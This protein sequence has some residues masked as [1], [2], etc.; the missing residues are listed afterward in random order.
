[1]SNTVQ[2]S[3]D[4]DGDEPIGPADTSYY[5]EAGRTEAV[6]HETDK[7]ED[8]VETIMLM[9]RRRRRYH[10]TDMM[11]R[12][13]RVA[14]LD[15]KMRNRTL[16]LY[17]SMLEKAQYTKVT[18]KIKNLSDFD[19]SEAIIPHGQVSKKQFIEVFHRRPYDLYG[20]LIDEEVKEAISD[21]KQKEMTAVARAMGMTYVS[22]KETASNKLMADTIAQLP[23]PYDR[24]NLF[25]LKPPKIQTDV[26]N[27]GWRAAQSAPPGFAP[28]PAPLSNSYGHEVFYSYD[29]SWERGKLN[30][31]G[32]YVYQ[33]MTTYEG[34][35]KDN[36]QKGVGI[37]TY[38]EGSTY[39][40]DWHYGRYS[41][42]GE[43]RLRYDTAIYKGQF[44]EGRRSGSGRIEF[45]CGLVYEGDYI[46]GRPHGRGKMTSA[47]TGYEYDGCWRD[48]GICGT[49]ALVTPPPEK[50]RV[51]RFWPKGKEPMQ[52]AGAIR[53]YISDIDRNRYNEMMKGATLFGTRRA[54]NL[55]KYVDAVRKE[56]HDER[57]AAKKQER[58]DAL[59]KWKEQKAKLHEAKMRALAG[60]EDDDDDETK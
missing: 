43:Q 22:D 16:L 18:Q 15:E 9:E 35:F 8:Q 27:V 50:K 48:G 25:S 7:T 38:D 45:R 29:G 5:D 58:A 47:L 41:G 53:W 37:A 19:R 56:I 39:N 57:Y 54:Y 42:I 49:G 10:C 6:T 34:E 30:G 24:D 59:A 4:D 11:S 31:R 32:K 13:A 26:H 51:I 46:D 14:E 23:D 60:I 40:G 3:L 55:K 28:D 1:M 20:R 21:E 52:L 2:F 17:K 36:R 44:R 33:D 12:G